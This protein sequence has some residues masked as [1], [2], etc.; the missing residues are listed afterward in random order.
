[1]PGTS[2]RLAAR[3]APVSADAIV[4]NTLSPRGECAT[5]GAAA[6]RSRARA[7]VHRD[8]I[9]ADHPTERAPSSR[10]R[11]ASRIATT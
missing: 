8:R 7:T 6:A 9:M 2:Q 4:P 5:M 10:P 11:N 3:Y 1:L